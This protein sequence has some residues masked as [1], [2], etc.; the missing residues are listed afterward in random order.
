[1]IADVAI[2]IRPT[3]RQRRR[4]SL[5]AAFLE[6]FVRLGDF[7]PKGSELAAAAGV[8]PSIVNHHFGSR[9]GVGFQLAQQQTRA[10]VEALGLSPH[11]L[12]ALSPRDARAIAVAVLAG[13]KLEPGE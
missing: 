5:V 10:V 6:R 7:Q 2:A 12:A 13:R 9:Q 4:A 11:A 8:A 1:M 3:R